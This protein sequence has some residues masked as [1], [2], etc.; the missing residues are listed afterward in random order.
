MQQRNA[1]GN[2]A[3]KPARP[4]LRALTGLRFFAAFAVV[5]YHFGQ[6]LLSHWPIALR[7][8]AASGYVAVSLFFL[9]SGFVLSY[10]Y[11]NPKGEMSGNKRSFYSARFARIYPAY[12]LAFLLAAPTNILW[13]LHV[14]R[15]PV[16]VMKLSVAAAAVLSLQQAW[17]PWTAWSWNFPAWSV[18]VEAFFYL[19]FPFLAPRLYR[20]RRSAC[21]PV[22]AG[23]W[24][25]PLCA[26]LLLYLLKGVTAESTRGDYLQIAVEF[27]PLLRLPEFLIGILLGRAFSLGTVLS[28]VLSEILSY[29]SAIGIF[30]VL[31]HSSAIPHP[32]LANGLLI[33]L[34]AVLVYSLAAGK[35]LLA[36]MLSLPV[37]VLLGEASYG[38]Y[39][40]QIPIAYVLR[41][42]PPLISLRM[43]TIFSTVL[44]V[45]ALLS[46]RFIE[47]PLKAPLRRWL[48]HPWAFPSTKQKVIESF[49]GRQLE[50]ALA[51]NARVNQHAGESNHRAGRAPG[52]PVLPAFVSKVSHETR[53][54]NQPQHINQHERK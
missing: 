13:S 43:F 46:W 41:M 14:N 48:S 45:A 1:A 3:S 2:Q 24:I 26:G 18:S 7:S 5:I 9:L 35:G 10:S 22:A 49:G 28:P 47:S 33:P 19:I 25:L 50:R 44:I 4:D 53:S 30:V 38:I 42:P 39:I 40:L 16:A 36:G 34:F 11:L 52:N 51:R 29:L 37:T 23:L 8:V 17:T 12:L 32:I 20:L 21:L 54:I 27:T 31:A 15:L 6:P